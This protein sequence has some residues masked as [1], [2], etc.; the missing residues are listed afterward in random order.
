MKLSKCINAIL[1]DMPAIQKLYNSYEHGE[2][3][4]SARKKYYNKYKRD[5]E[6]LD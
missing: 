5:R 6:I 4:M 3:K 2:S 1:T